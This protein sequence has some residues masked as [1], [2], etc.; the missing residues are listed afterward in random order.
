MFRGGKFTLSSILTSH[1]LTVPL[2]CYPTVLCPN[3]LKLLSYCPTV[4]GSYCLTV[5]MSFCTTVL[6][7]YD[8][9]VA[10]TY[11]VLVSYGLSVATMVTV[12]V[13]YCL[14]VTVSYCIRSY[15]LVV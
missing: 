5:L 12:L 15:C 3:V 2:S 7:S 8:L 1:C 4:S 11:T 10:T 13:S 14:T 9:S 6:V